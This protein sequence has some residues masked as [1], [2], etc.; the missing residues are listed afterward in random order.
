[1]L[2]LVS[3]G[4][5]KHTVL[6]RPTVPLYPVSSLSSRTAASAAVSPSSIS[7]AGNCGDIKRQRLSAVDGTAA[8]RQR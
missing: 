8:V 4:S 7:P 2:A 5:E 6:M 3:P 1:M